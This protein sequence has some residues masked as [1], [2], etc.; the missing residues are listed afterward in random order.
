M[1][2]NDARIRRIYTRQQ[3]ETIVDDSLDVSVDN[4]LVVEWEAGSVINGLGVSLDLHVVTRDISTNAN[5]A[6][7]L[8]DTVAVTTSGV[9][10][11]TGY[12]EV[13]AIPAGTL[14]SGDM[15]ESLASLTRAASQIHSFS[16]EW[17]FLGF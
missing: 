7:P 15:Y 3:G 10:A 8:T 4:E 1:N 16:N 11:N 5:E 6:A 14:A 13:I 9:A 2:P 12:T 17:L